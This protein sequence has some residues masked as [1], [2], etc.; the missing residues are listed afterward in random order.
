[1][2][3]FLLLLFRNIANFNDSSWVRSLLY[4][5]YAYTSTRNTHTQ[6]ERERECKTHVHAHQFTNDG[7]SLFISFFKFCQKKMLNQFSVFLHSFLFPKGIWLVGRLLA[8]L[9]YRKIKMVVHPEK[10]MLRSN[11][12]RRYYCWVSFSRSLSSSIR[13]AKNSKWNFDKTQNKHGRCG[14]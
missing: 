2:F 8:V 11:S 1:M 3:F 6:T 9:M 4:T 7:Y 10:R 13:S 5:W 12:M 14:V